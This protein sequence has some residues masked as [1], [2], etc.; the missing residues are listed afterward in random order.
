MNDPQQI[1]RFIEA[2]SGSFSGSEEI[3]TDP[4]SNT[5]MDAHGTLVNETA[6][7]GIAINSAY[8]QD[9]GGKIS[10]RCQTLLRIDDSGDVTMVWMPD[11]GDPAIY[12]GSLDGSVIDVSRTTEDGIAQRIRTDYGDGS[13]VTTEMRMT[14]PGVDESTTV[15]SGRY[16]RSGPPGDGSA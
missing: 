9:M 8:Q 12:T 13:S 6:L 15:F 5:T 1:R 14:F 2:C 16:A 10:I 7:G 3:V 4:G 11:D